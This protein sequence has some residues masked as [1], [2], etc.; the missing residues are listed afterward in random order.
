[1][2]D[3]DFNYYSNYWTTD[4]MYFRNSVGY[5]KTKFSWAN[6]WLDLFSAKTAFTLSLE[7]CLS[8]NASATSSSPNLGVLSVNLSNLLLQW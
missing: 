4:L 8:T 5:L 2:I 6:D 7:K 1:M 3:C